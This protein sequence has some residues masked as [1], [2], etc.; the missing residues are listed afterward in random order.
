MPC[1]KHEMSCLVIH[2]KGTECSWQNEPCTCDE[3]KPGKV[4]ILCPHQYIVSEWTEWGDWSYGDK[5]GG[6]LRAS[7]L[8]C[9]KCFEEKEV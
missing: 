8:I 4:K 7:R 9:T 5:R 2:P 3:L 1:K 6:E